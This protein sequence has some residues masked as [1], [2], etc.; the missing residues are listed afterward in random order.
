MTLAKSLAVSVCMLL[1][2]LVPSAASSEPDPLSPEGYWKT[3]DDDGKTATSVMQLWF[4]QGKLHGRIVKLYL[5]QGDDS[6]P[7]CEKCSGA[8]KDKKILGM[9][10]LF[11]LSKDDDEWSGGSILDPESGNSYKCYVQV[12]QG[13][14]QLK[15][16][17]YVGISLL[18]RT[19]YWSR[20]KKPSEKVEFTR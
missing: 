11:N 14:K 13:G 18:G 7:A 4:Y 17:G 20:T 6:D 1:G 2:L 16:R 15:V 19:Q 8:N 9:Q 5:K 12:Q 10:I 3:I